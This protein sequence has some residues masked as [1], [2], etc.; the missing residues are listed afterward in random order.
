MIDL[1]GVWLNQNGSRLTFT[2]PST[3]QLQGVFESK[4]GRAAKGISYPVVGVQNGEVLSFIVDFNSEEEN[5]QSLTTFSG[6]YLRNA[7]G[8]DQI[9]TMWILTRQFEDENR[10]RPTSVWNSFLTNSDIFTRIATT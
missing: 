1:S 7:E 3:G 6:R 4:K 2:T 9:H 8:E 5:L 10:T